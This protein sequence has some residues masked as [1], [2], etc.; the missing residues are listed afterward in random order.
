[1]TAGEQRYVMMP[2]VPII[3]K[4][5]LKVRVSAYGPMKTDTEEIEIEVIVSQVVCYHH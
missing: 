4:G 2:I 5:T 3:E 1:M